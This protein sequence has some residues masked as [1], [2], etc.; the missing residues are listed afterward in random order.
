MFIVHSGISHLTFMTF[1]VYAYEMGLLI[2]QKDVMKIIGSKATK[3][4]T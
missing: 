2:I 4:F 1:R 3:S